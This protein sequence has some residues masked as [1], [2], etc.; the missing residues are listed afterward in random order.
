MTS[1]ERVLTT[2]AG[3]EAD[4]VPINYF[5]NPDIDRRM[6]SHFGL[7]KDEREGLLQALGV[8][9]RT[10]SVPTLAPSDTRMS[11]IVLSTSGAFTAGGSNTKVAATGI[12]VSSRSRTPSSKRLIPGRCLHLT[13]STTA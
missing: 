8:D 4:R 10:V 7:A 6:K 5:A 3:G 9:F 1:R 2:F 12:T 11:R 13:A